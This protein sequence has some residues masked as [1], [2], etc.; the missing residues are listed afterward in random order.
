MFCE[1]LYHTLARPINEFQLNT[2]KIIILII[3]KYELEGKHFD[4]L[5]GLR[6]F[7]KNTLLKLAIAG[8]IHI[9]AY[10]VLTEYLFIY[11][12]IHSHFYIELTLADVLHIKML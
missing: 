9:R 8:K 12:I 6:K 5:H 3:K 10:L 2:K 4:G 11:H 1:S 7:H